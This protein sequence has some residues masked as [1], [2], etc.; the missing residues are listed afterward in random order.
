MTSTFSRTLNGNRLPCIFLALFMIA[1]VPGCAAKKAV[2]A[3]AP[4]PSTGH[5]LEKI[6]RTDL[7]TKILRS[8]A[9][10][11][12][13]SPDGVFSTDC[14]LIA[15]FPSSLRVETIP[16]LGPPD[17]FLALR[18]DSLKVFLPRKGEFYISRG[19]KQNLSRF[20]PL[21]LDA[22]EVIPLFMGM[23]PPGMLES[24]DLLRGEEEEGLYRID[25]F[26]AAKKRRCS[27]WF[28]PS[29]NVLSR[30]EFFG[31]GGKVLYSVRFK[32]YRMV[33]GVSL[34]GRVEIRVGGET[35]ESVPT[36]LSLRYSDPQL[37]SG[38]EDK[39]C[40]DL[41]IPSGVKPIFLD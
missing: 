9:H 32:D 28:D 2:P 30:F 40:F 34:P 33:N 38:E 14:A 5:I 23:L 35:E 25:A 6:S 20:I 8:T 24:R 7:R 41:E 10:I 18:D 16:L 29:E 21:T 27:L 3:G 11:T 17:F 4:L 15:K 1:L 31:A 37:S 12:V 13:E 19:P 36:L 39:A 26:S 22:R